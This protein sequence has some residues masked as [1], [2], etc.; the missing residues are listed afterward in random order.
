VERDPW[1]EQNGWYRLE[2]DHRTLEELRAEL[3]ELRVELERV[4]AEIESFIDHLVLRARIA[5]Y[6]R[7]TS[8]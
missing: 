5:A 2:H 1:L 6:T 4:A 3:A 8:T 7:D